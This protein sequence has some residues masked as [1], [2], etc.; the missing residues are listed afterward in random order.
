M[1]VFSIM[2]SNDPNMT[3]N[4]NILKLTDDALSTADFAQVWIE[5]IQAC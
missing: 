4:S 2:T 1:L 3:L 5:F